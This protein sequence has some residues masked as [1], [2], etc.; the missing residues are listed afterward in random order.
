MCSYDLIDAKDSPQQHQCTNIR[1]DIEQDWMQVSLGVFM[2]ISSTPVPEV[3]CSAHLPASG[4][5]RNP[6][7]VLHVPCNP[8]PGTHKHNF[9]CDRVNAGVN[10]LIWCCAAW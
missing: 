9:D 2:V 8:A 1:H 7:V 4:V 5:P 10:G 3:S 6:R